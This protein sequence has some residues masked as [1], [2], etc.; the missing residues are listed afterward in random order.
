MSI[1]DRLTRSARRAV[2][3]ALDKIDQ[4]A[5]GHARGQVDALRADLSPRLD[6][7]RDQLD[8]QP[9]ASTELADLR[10]EIE[11]LHAR[12]ARLEKLHDDRRLG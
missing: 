8:D 11:I 1:R 5:A 4:I 3:P 2:Q 10:A 6:R 9:G 7:L 12:V